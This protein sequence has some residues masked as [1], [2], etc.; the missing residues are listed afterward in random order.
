M[1]ASISTMA[2]AARTP[3]THHELSKFHGSCKLMRL[4][5]LASNATVSSGMYAFKPALAESPKAVKILK[6]P[7]LIIP[8]FFTM[9][10]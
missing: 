10:R 3:I 1:S 7:F 9:I 6:C 8:Y 2:S 4:V 5:N